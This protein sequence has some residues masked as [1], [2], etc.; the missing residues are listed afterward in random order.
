MKD[1][2]LDVQMD[3]RLAI[4][5][6][7]SI[8]DSVSGFSSLAYSL[9]AARRRCVMRTGSSGFGGEEGG[10]QGHVADVAAGH[11]EPGKL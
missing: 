9:R 3:G 4:H 8:S 11:V 2:F 1:Q 10:V 5:A 6:Q 7:P